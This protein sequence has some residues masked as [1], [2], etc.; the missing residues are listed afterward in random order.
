VLLAQIMTVDG[1]EITS[2]PTS[3]IA[4]GATVLLRATLSAEDGRPVRGVDAAQAVVLRAEPPPDSGLEPIL[5]SPSQVED[6]GLDSGDQVLF[7]M[8]PLEAVGTYRMLAE[9]RVTPSDRYRARTRPQRTAVLTA[10]DF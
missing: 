4:A 8:P 10:T 7:A 5:M 6:S 3:D 2:Q 9:V 1:E